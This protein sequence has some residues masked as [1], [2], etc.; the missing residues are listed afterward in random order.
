MRLPPHLPDEEDVEITPATDERVINVKPARDV[1]NYGG[2]RGHVPDFIRCPNCEEESLKLNQ[3]KT[4]RV[5]GEC[6]YSEP[7]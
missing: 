1:T 2:K 3:R 4:L 7:A 6:G 5:C